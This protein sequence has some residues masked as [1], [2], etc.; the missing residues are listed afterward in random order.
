VGNARTGTG[1]AALLCALALVGCTADAGVTPSP[2]PS[3]S[4]ASPT[5]SDAE[6]QERLDYAAAEKA[7][8]TFRAEYRRVQR[9]GGAS[10]ASEVMR[11]TAAGEYL[12]AFTD[13]I[14]GYKKLGTRAVG[15]EEIV[16]VRPA[17]YQTASLLLDVCEDARQIRTVRKS[18]EAEVGDLREARVEVRKLVGTWKLW[19][20]SGEVV[21][22]CD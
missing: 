13:V 15:Q 9:Q 8:R 22:R 20:G 18:G 6:R 17:G 11:A 19:A 1:V 7:Y 10:D 14:R 4:S 5:E 12:S 16:F 3:A 2:S 21:Q